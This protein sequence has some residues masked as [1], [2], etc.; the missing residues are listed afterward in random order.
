[1]AQYE[2]LL[3]DQGSD[4][5]VEIHLVNVNGSKKNL[6]GYSVNSQIRRTVN[7][8]DSDAIN[9]TAIIADPT[10]DG[11]ITLVLTNIQTMALTDRR[12]FYDVEISHV[13]SDATTF[14][15]K[16]LYGNI[17]INPNITRV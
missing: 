4:V 12:Y 9:F 6:T 17:N 1:M 10:T 7:S 5:A 15:E 13:D 11:I 14:I 8:P 16:V 3:I 2:D